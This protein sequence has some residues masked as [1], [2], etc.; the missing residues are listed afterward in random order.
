MPDDQIL[1]EGPV[2]TPVPE[3]ADFLTRRRSVIAENMTAPGPDAPTLAKL[4]KIA[5]RVPDHGKLAPWRFILFEG[6]ARARFGDILGAAFAA[7]NPDAPDKTLEY[8]RNRFLRAPVVVAVIAAAAP[9][10]KIPEWEQLMSAGAACQNLLIA[11]QAMGF[12]G[13]WLTE[14]YAYDETVKRALGAAPHEH[15]AGYIY[16]GTAKASPKERPRPEMAEIVS[17]WTLPE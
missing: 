7:A 17:Y 5:A 1:S 9:H 4:L 10:P 8:E 16:L 2:F 6:E 3:V 15:V 11:A 13:Q 12:A 14:W